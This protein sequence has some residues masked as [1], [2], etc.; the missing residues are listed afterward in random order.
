MI[1]V[2]QE[3]PHS[4]L[5]SSKLVGFCPKTSG[6]GP[7]RCCRTQAL[8]GFQLFSR[9]Q[10]PNAQGPKLR[11]SVGFVSSP[12]PLDLEITDGHSTLLNITCAVRSLTPDGSLLDESSDS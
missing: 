10:R 5:E 12:R 8:T 1:P 9:S 7:C 2:R 3:A 11:R 4:S 6:P